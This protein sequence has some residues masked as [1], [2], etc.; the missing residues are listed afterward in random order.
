ML[1]MVLGRRRGTLDHCFGGNV[2]VTLRCPLVAGKDAGKVWHL[3]ASV[4]FI[5]SAGECYIL[6]GRGSCREVQFFGIFFF[7]FSAVASQCRQRRS[8][9][10]VLLGDPS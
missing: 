5:A 10:V 6:T 2:G 8:Q 1:A 3:G 9:V 4:F 7:S